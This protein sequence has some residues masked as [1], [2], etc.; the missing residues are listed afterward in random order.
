MSYVTL[1]VYAGR[2]NNHNG[3]RARRS[4]GLNGAGVAREATGWLSAML[5]TSGLER[6]PNVL[7]V[8]S[9]LRAIR[10]GLLRMWGTPE[11]GPGFSANSNAKYDRRTKYAPAGSGKWLTLRSCV[12]LV[13]WPNLQASH[14]VYRCFW[15]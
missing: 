5:S 2:L 7:T 10:E 1:V 9:S 13:L 4:S 11:A 14:A 3:A 12:G 8:C 6:L 15:W